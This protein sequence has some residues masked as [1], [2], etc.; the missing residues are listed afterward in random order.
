MGGFVQK[1]K[2]KLQLGFGGLRNGSP[3]TVMVAVCWVCMAML[4]ISNW[5][6]SLSAIRL[7]RSGALCK[8]VISTS[9]ALVRAGVNE[10][11]N[12][13]GQMTFSRNLPRDISPCFRAAW[14]SWQWT[15]YVADSGRLAGHDEQFPKIVENKICFFFRQIENLIDSFFIKTIWFHWIETLL[16]NFH[17][18]GNLFSLNVKK[19]GQR[20]QMRN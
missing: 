17:V 3:R 9:A 4:A 10:L 5:A 14:I 11:A 15:E 16:G 7:A 8:C 19:I 2:K 1:N 18:M 20:W 13:R 12:K 6:E